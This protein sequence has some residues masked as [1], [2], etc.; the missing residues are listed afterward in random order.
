MSRH[1]DPWGDPLVQALLWLLAILLV[2]GTVA[3]LLVD[4]VLTH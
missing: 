1:R 3:A 4:P 2:V